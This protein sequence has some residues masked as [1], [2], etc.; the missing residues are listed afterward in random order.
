MSSS[1]ADPI[2]VTSLLDDWREGDEQAGRRLIEVVY[3]ELKRLAALNLRREVN[4][5]TLQPT[6][7]VNEL[8]LRI[9]SGPPLSCENRLHFLHLASRQMRRLMVDH[10]RRK[11][12]LKRGGPQPQLALDE[13]R[14]FAAV[15]LDDRVANLND[16]LVR[17]EKIDARPAAVVEM[18]FFGG[19]TEEEIAGVLGIS[20]ATVKRDWEFARSWLLAQLDGNSPH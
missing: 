16:A 12:G 15:L 1:E 2:D 8:C 7:L 11:K 6:A 19:L 17:L 3:R 13:A 20:T 18:R 9:L 10:A 4:A 5:I 14:D